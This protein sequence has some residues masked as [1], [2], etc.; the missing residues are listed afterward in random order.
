MRRLTEDEYRALIPIGP[1]GEF[2]LESTLD[3]LV[4][5]GFARWVWDDNEK[6]AVFVPTLAGELALRIEERIRRPL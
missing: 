2:A 6:Q 1:E 3:Q 4:A 5:D